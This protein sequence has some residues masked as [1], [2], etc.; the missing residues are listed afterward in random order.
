M[1]TTSYRI[2]FNPAAAAAA[3][4]CA[5]CQNGGNPMDIDSPDVLI[6][7]RLDDLETILQ[8]LYNTKL[9]L[10]ALRAASHGHDCANTLRER[11]D[12]QRQAATGTAAAAVVPAAP[13]LMGPPPRPTAIP[14]RGVTVL[15]N[16]GIPNGGP[17]TGTSLGTAFSWNSR[18]PSGFMGNNNLNSRAPPMQATS[19]FGFGMQNS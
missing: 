19:I 18:Q 16:A 6:Y 12:A 5:I 7:Q 9:E 15:G 3:C 14:A 13:G 2:A 17:S 11:I 1:D 4:G 10:R 8:E